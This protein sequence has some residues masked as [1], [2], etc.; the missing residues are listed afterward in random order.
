MT[1]TPSISAR[2]QAAG[3][4]SLSLIE[5]KPA[6]GNKVPNSDTEVGAYLRS[7]ST[8]AERELHILDC[9]RLML[10]AMERYEASSCFTD[11]GD[12]QRFLMLQNEAIRGRSAEQVA[13]MEQ[14]RRLA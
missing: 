12:A 3:E 14:E 11:L 2:P 4:I 9:G 13:R 8:D 10:A 5:A 1:P 7:E 6:V